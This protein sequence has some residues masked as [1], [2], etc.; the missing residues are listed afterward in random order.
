MSTA[1]HNTLEYYEQLEILT[2][3]VPATK[4]KSSINTLRFLN[5]LWFPCATLCVGSL[6]PYF[7]FFKIKGCLIPPAPLFLAHDSAEAAARKVIITT[8]KSTPI[9]LWAHSITLKQETLSG[10]KLKIQTQRIV[11]HQRTS[12]SKAHSHVYFSLT[13]LYSLSFWRHC[14]WNANSHKLLPECRYCYS[15]SP[16]MWRIVSSLLRSRHRPFSGSHS[17]VGCESTNRNL[18]WR[19]WTAGAS[20]NVMTALDSAHKAKEKLTRP[21]QSLFCFITAILTLY[22]L[23][24]VSGLDR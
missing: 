17:K 22:R 14:R 21:L 5:L 2:L 15:A 16:H 18:L 13:A 8:L 10:V 7:L 20:Q 9:S 4:P 1:T 24:S 12:S 3:P 19:E 11:C 6:L 23:I